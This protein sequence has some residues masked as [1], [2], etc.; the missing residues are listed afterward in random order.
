M[1]NFMLSVFY[2]PN[3]ILISCFLRFML[4]HSTL[5]KVTPSFLKILTLINILRNSGCFLNHLTK[6]M[7]FS[8]YS[9][10]WRK[11]QKELFKRVKRYSLASDSGSSCLQNYHPKHA[12]KF[13]WF[14]KTEFSNDASKTGDLDYKWFHKTEILKERVF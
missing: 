12:C 2:H 3:G 10:C 14:W 13:S 6:C 4:K 5:S 7:S 1:V 9:V 11:E 8:D